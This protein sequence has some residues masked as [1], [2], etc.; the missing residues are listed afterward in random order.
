MPILL[1]HALSMECFALVLGRDG[2][3][4]D[5]SIYSFAVPT[6]GKSGVIKIMPLG[7]G[8][9]HCQLFHGY[10]DAWSI[11]STKHNESMLAVN[12]QNAMSP[13]QS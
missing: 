2:Q 7:C 6:C 5:W 10:I 8:R 4:F 13:I 1:E 9:F 11:N 12:I 3:V